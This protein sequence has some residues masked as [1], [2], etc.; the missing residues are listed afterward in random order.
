[1]KTSNKILLIAGATPVLIVFLLMILFKILPLKDKE[2]QGLSEITAGQA[3]NEQTV[4]L[5]DFN[6]ISATGAWDIRLV[7]S[8]EYSVKI[9]T[10][11]CSKNDTGALLLINDRMPG[12]QAIA[13]ISLPMI[14]SIDMTGNAN[15]RLSGF[16][17]D[18]LSIHIQG[19][20]N[21]SGTG[22]Q[23]TKLALTGEGILNADLTGVAVSNADIKCNG[24]YTIGL[25]MK[26]GRLSGMLNGA[27]T[28]TY[29]GDVSVNEIQV[30]NPEG[31]VLH[32]SN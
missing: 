18:F 11:V 15:L 2:S 13:T 21:I 10:G 32:F 23:I 28:V 16:K 1:M 19:T 30:A 22:S 20:S 25:L 7:R 4:P 9:E 29:Q 31:K 27:G 24:T 3:A 8:D 5:Y 17:A 26:G 6:G 14:S 12:K